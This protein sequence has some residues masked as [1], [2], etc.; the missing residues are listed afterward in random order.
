MA[1]PYCERNPGVSRTVAL[2]S[3][4]E[5]AAMPR[6]QKCGGEMVKAETDMT[7]LVAG[8]YAA[9]TG[10]TGSSMEKTTYIK[11]GGFYCPTCTR[12]ATP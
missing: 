10:L 5:V 9:V 6:C 7:R 2:P 8:E 3:G 1:C 4:Q 11:A 12:A